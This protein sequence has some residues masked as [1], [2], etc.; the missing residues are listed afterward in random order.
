MPLSFALSISHFVSS[1]GADA[2]F[3]ALIGLAILVLLYFAHAR[4]TSNV[5][6]ELVRANERLEELERRLTAG[7]SPYVAPRPP[8]AAPG[9]EGEDAG[10]IAGAEVAPPSSAVAPG[11]GAGAGAGASHL[12]GAPALTPPAGVGAPPLTDATRVVPGVEQEASESEEAPS[13]GRPAE[14]PSEGQPAEAPVAAVPLA[15]PQG[16]GAAPSA[17]VTGAQAPP[18]PGSFRPGAFGGD[19]PPPVVAPPPGVGRTPAPVTAAAGGNGTSATLGA[20]SGAPRSLLEHGLPSRHRSLKWLIPLVAG[21]VL[22]AIAVVLVVVLTSG[23]GTPGHRAA[24]R[25]VPPKIAAAPSGISPAAVTVAV[26]NGT[27]INQLAHHVGDRLTRLGF[28]EGALATATGQTLSTTSVG[29]LP[30]Y[31]KDGLLVAHALKLPAAN[32]RPAAQSN[33]SL[34]CPQPTSCTADVVVVAGTDL[35]PHH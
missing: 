21:L 32:V 26:V 2:G 25:H 7:V 20:S 9:M 4:E 23:N 6:S 34:V 12:G 8:I 27:S 3:A 15:A 11:A 14:A 30:G 1:V 18:A 29:Y 28:K 10:G 16:T 19:R 24:A 17:T 5:R 22:V 13:E 33:L 31:H 35:A